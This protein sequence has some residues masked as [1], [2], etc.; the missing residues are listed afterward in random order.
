[1]A[2]GSIRMNTVEIDNEDKFKIQRPNYSTSAN[3]LWNLW[4]LFY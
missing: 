3:F 4:K 2:K 1:M